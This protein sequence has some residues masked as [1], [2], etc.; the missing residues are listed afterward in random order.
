MSG[1]CRTGVVGPQLSS[2]VGPQDMRLHLKEKTELKWF[3]R[4]WYLYAA[5]SLIWL[6]GIII[7]E[8]K[9]GGINNR[10]SFYTSNVFMWLV[11]TTV[12][13]LSFFKRRN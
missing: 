12:Y 4:M 6:L 9:G 2:T 1:V 8:T 11:L 5:A 7:L 10:F 13:V 3:H